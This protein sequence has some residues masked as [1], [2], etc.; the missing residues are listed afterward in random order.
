MLIES[1]AKYL[2]GLGYGNYYPNGFN[3]NNNIFLN[4]YPQEPQNL[5]SIYDT[6]GEGKDIGMSHSRRNVQ[7]LVRG[8]SQRNTNLLIWYIHNALTSDST[9]GF[10][11][12]DDRKMLVKSINTPTF[13]G[14]DTNGLFEFSV[15]FSI[16][17]RDDLPY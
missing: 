3:E 16:W 6:G 15:N 12:I 2:D 9:N 11:F 8:T 13:I 14:K 5:I 17:S 4:N 1:I 10:I 7:I